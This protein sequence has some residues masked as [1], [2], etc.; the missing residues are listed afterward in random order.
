MCDIYALINWSTM[1][2][3]RSA[4]PVRSLSK[5]HREDNASGATA[6]GEG[7]LEDKSEAGGSMWGAVLACGLNI[8]QK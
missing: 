2:F 1:S 4:G 5:A 7:A 3:T 8:Y 6:V